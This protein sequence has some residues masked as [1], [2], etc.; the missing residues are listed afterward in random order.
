[1]GAAYDRILAAETG[2]ARRVALGVIV[3][4]P[5]RPLL[6]IIPGMFIVDFLRRTAA[7]RRYAR[8]YLPPRKAALDAARDRVNGLD[9]E[10]ALKEAGVTARAWLESHGVPGEE[11]RQ[12]LAGLMEEMVEHDLRLLRSEGATYPDLIRTAYGSLGAYR[13][14]LSRLAERERA[15]IGALS[16]AVGDEE[17]RRQLEEEQETAEEQREKEADAVFL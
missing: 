14:F 9:R 8:F 10:E 2:F 4:R 17:A 15:F 16:N 13:T 11:A 12:A 5:V 1:M 6:Q 7:I 3:K